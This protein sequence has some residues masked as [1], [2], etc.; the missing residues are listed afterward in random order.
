MYLKYGTTGADERRCAPPMQKRPI[1]GGK[2]SYY[3]GKRDLK[4][5]TTGADERRSA[6]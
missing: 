2:E 6:H 1:V 4:Y 5:G 3:R